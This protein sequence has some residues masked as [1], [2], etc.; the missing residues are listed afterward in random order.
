[1]TESKN[2]RNRSQ[3]RVTEGGNAWNKVNQC[4][5]LPL[6]SIGLRAATDDTAVAAAAR[7]AVARNFIAKDE[8]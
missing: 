6:T 1:M 7:I 5:P 8:E 3:I 2:A 4:V